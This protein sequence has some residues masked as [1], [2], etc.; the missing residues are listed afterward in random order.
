MQLN[1]DAQEVVQSSAIENRSEAVFRK[2]DQQIILTSSSGA[3]FKN[4]SL[5]KYKLDN[6]CQAFGSYDL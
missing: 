4:W 6:I 2:Q 1:N 3:G 5:R